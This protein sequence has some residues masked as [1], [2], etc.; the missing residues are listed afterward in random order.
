MADITFQYYDEGNTG[1]W[2]STTLDNIDGNYGRYTS[3]AI[4]SNDKVHISY[5]DV[6]G[7][8]LYTSPSPRDS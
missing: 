8:L 3:L 6:S 4:D 5:L 7:C 1:D 2:S